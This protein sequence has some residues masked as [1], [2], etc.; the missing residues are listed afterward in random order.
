MADLTLRSI[1]GSPLTLAEVDAN[2]TALNTEFE[3]KL[4]ITSYTAAD[5]LSKLLTVDGVSSGLD[6]DKVHDLSPTAS[7]VGLSLV[8]RN[9]SG[10][11][12]A[13]TITANLTG[14]VTGDIF[15]SDGTTRILDNGTGANATFTGNVTGNTSGSA[16][17]LANSRTI[18]ITGDG[19]WSTSFNGSANVTGALTLANSGVTAGTYTKITVD[20]KGRATSGTSLS[21]TDVTNAL[22]YIPWHS[23][24]DGAGSGLDADLLDGYNS[25]TAATANTIALRDASGNLTANVFTGV[26]TSA[27][28]AD[29]AEKYTTDQKY[30]VGTVVVI[31][32]KED[33]ECTA[34]N[35]IGQPSIGVISENPAFLMNSESSGQAVAIK[36]RVPVRV[37]GPIRKGETLCA[38]TNGQATLG[39]VN[40]IAIA[41]KTDLTHEEK[42]VECFIL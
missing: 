7:N 36:G 42:L 4:S 17:T 40:P 26:A 16:G 5:V 24:N 21:G 1:K 3:T 11:F 12:A 19:A 35:Y 25:A 34:S 37:I 10:N 14:N 39:Q 30:P 41:L 13:G 29:L 32:D 15:A 18:S 6:A 33:F 23:G 20:A 31:S 38:A 22:G 2:F 27:R 8:S 28:Y 9:S